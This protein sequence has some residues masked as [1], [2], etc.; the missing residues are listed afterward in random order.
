VID[1]RISKGILSHSKR[2]NE[3]ALSRI[4]PESVAVVERIGVTR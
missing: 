4:T 3:A 2:E 1:Y